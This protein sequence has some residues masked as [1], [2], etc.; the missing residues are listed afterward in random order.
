[1]FNSCDEFTEQKK[2]YLKRNAKM[3]KQ[4]KPV[5]IVISI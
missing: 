1:M 3:I 4:P 5:T 2:R